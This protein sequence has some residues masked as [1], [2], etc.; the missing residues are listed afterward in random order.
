MTNN[1]ATAARPLPAPAAA[2][3]A[4]ARFA[5][6]PTVPYPSHFAK[7]TYFKKREK[8]GQSEEGPFTIQTTLWQWLIRP[9]KS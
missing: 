4:A 9:K 8:K 3:P 5:G 1:A 2:A 7:E 6:L